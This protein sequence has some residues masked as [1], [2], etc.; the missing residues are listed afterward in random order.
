[1]S[2]GGS[3]LRDCPVPSSCS[4]PLTH[5]HLLAEDLDDVLG[6]AND[7]AALR[8]VNFL[9]PLRDLALSEFAS[10]EKLTSSSLSVFETLPWAGSAD[11]A[12]FAHVW[13]HART[14]AIPMVRVSALVL[15]RRILSAV[16]VSADDYFRNFFLV[17]SALHCQLVAHF[18]GADQVPRSCW[19]RATL[20]IQS[21]LSVDQF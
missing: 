15:I 7:V 18:V 12:T 16:V 14:V 1:M 2:S 17:L 6:D 11:L 20:M 4:E 19:S 5:R 21:F 3:V 10:S 13:S 9:N 8:P